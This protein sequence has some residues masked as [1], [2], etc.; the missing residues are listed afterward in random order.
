[1]AGPVDNPWLRLSNTEI[2]H[3]AGQGNWGAFRAL[4]MDIETIKNAARSWERPLSRENA[5]SEGTLLSAWART[6]SKT[7]GWFAFTWTSRS[8]PVS[9]ATSK[10]FLAM[11]RIEGEQATRQAQR[12]DHGLGGEYLVAL[13]L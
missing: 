9:R 12:S 6:A 11:H 2:Q 10:V 8:F 5:V 3:R 1:M 7:V 4:S 13:L